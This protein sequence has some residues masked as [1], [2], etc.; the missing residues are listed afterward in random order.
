MDIWFSRFYGPLNIWIFSF[1]GID[2]YDRILGLTQAGT[3][4]SCF[5]ATV[6]NAG[7][8]QNYADLLIP[9]S[10]SSLANCPSVSIIWVSIKIFRFQ[11]DY[12]GAHFI[13]HKGSLFPGSFLFL[14][15]YI[16]IFI[17]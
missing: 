5:H 3:K 7:E 2:L 4:G 10:S 17:K 6:A 16:Y 14:Y 15:L 12:Q 8:A 1:V 11:L 13:K 9:F